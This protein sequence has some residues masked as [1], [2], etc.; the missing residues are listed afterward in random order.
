MRG[1][2]VYETKVPA[3]EYNEEQC[4]YLQFQGVNASTKVFF[5][6]KEVCKHYNGYST[7]RVEITQL[8]KEENEIRVEVDNSKNGTVYP[9]VADITFYG[10][11]YREVEFLVVSKYHFDLDY[12]GG[13]GLVYTS[14]VKENRGK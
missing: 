5:Y 10:G 4:V 1:N 7:F 14:K 2:C 13:G 8:L 9:Q 11:I 12:Y 6:G 3:P